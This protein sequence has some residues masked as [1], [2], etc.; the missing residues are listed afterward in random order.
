MVRG[1]VNLDSITILS[2]HQTLAHPCVCFIKSTLLD[3]KT[4]ITPNQ[5]KWAFSTTQFL[6]LMGYLN[7]N[8][9]NNIRI[10]RHHAFNEPNRYLQNIPPITKGY[11][12]YSV[13]HGSFFKIDHTLEHKTSLNKFKKPEITPCILIDNNAIKL[14]ISSKESLVRTQTHGD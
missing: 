5:W 7:K 12:Y 8:K 9:Q 10:K 6:P 1:R 4:K 11:T 3:V 2:A 14:K 13:L